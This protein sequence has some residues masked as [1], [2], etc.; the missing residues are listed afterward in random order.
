[1]HF[2]AKGYDKFGFSISVK[3]VHTLSPVISEAMQERWLWS[4]YEVF[5]VRVVRVASPNLGNE[6]RW[7]AT[8]DVTPF[9]VKPPQ[10]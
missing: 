8:D 10:Y 4:F 1:M 5:T 6:D 9:Y 3:M 7:P 2:L